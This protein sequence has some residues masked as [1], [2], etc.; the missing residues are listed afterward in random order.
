MTLKDLQTRWKGM[1]V[2]RYLEVVGVVLRPRDRL[3]VC[4][5]CKKLVHSRDLKYTLRFSSIGPYHSGCYAQLEKGFSDGEIQ[6]EGEATAD[7][8]GT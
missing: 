4:F 6:T 7:R 8:S 1:T 2:G 3:H 5:R